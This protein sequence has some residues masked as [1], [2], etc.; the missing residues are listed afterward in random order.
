[1]KTTTS[2]S[3]S[4]SRDSRRMASSSSPTRSALT[5]PA[6]SCAPCFP[7][8]LLAH[9]PCLKEL[10]EAF[11]YER[12]SR[13][14]THDLLHQIRL[15]IHFVGVGCVTRR[16][17]IRSWRRGA[18]TISAQSAYAST[19]CLT[20][21]SAHSASRHCMRGNSDPTGCSRMSWT[22]SSTASCR[23]KWVVCVVVL[24]NYA[25][26]EEVTF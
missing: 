6:A 1:M 11:K 15:C 21:R 25:W 8:S 22:F 19:S 4:R 14:T 7:R 20:N 12:N 17:R 9:F 26:L 18:R 10:E 16:S 24:P 2:V 23:G 13:C 3:L 5:S